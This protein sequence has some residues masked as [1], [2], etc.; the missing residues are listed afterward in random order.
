MTLAF[1]KRLSIFNQYCVP[2]LRRTDVK[3]Y[4]YDKNGNNAT[5]VDE[6]D[7]VIADA[8]VEVHNGTP[9]KT[10]DMYY[11]ALNRMTSWSDG[12][13][14]ES[15]ANRGI[16]SVRTSKTSN[17]T[18]TTYL[19]DGLRELGEYENGTLVSLATSN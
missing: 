8:I 10:T 18:T 19:H 11:D 16:E 2:R 17:G 3:T 1:I 7:E 13:T 12:T 4:A 15:Y 6:D 14:T 9:F 5:T